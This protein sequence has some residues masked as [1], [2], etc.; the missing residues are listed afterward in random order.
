MA[1]ERVVTSLPEQLKAAYAKGTTASKSLKTFAG[2]ALPVSYWVVG[3]LFLIGMILIFIPYV[4]EEARKPPVAPVAQGQVQQP[5]DDW[6]GKVNTLSITKGGPVKQIMVPGGRCIRW[7]GPDPD[8]NAF[9]AYVRDVN[10]KGWTLWDEYRKK[11]PGRGFGW[12]RFELGGDEATVSYA[13]YKLD[14]CG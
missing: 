10:E 12:V 4:R 13:F 2:K 5:Q 8:G 7:W 14:E 1:E 11:Y 3:I 6:Y 9:I